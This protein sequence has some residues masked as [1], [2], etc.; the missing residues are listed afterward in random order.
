[1]SALKK[2]LVISLHGIRT[3]GEWQK[4]FCP[5]ISELGWKYYPLDYGYFFAAQLLNPFSHGS[6]V[7]W[8]RNEIN[9]I[10][11]ENGGVTPSIVV[12]SFGSLILGKAIQKYPDLKFD[13]I[14][15]TGSIMSRCFPWKSAYEKE[16]FTHVLNIIGKKDI[17]S[18]IAHYV[19][20][21]GGKSG[22][23]GFYE[24]SLIEQVEEYSYDQFG[25]GDAHFSDVFTSR[26]IPFLES[27]NSISGNEGTE[28]YLT[29]V[30]PQKAACWTVVT[31]VRQFID[32]FEDALK[33]NHFYP[34]SI[35]EPVK[36]S[37]KTFPTELVVLIPD[38]PR[39]ASKLGRELLC[40]KLKL[41][42][43]A[44]GPRSERTALISKDGILYDLPSALESFAVYN[45]V[46]NKPSGGSEALSEFKTI[47]TDVI[48]RRFG[49][50]GS[51][52]RIESLTEVLNNQEK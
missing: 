28:N 49:S 2:R 31:Y 22:A 30:T 10:C 5:Y 47:L 34:R 42:P 51:S 26:V 40:K 17:W 21:G 37:I 19:V 25:H 20:D 32:R 7:L 36:D 23:A 11:E 1:M 43:I 14:V 15:L 33:D 4:K 12:H 52:V 46:N 6:K 50:L 16:Q 24:E 9:R 27:S 13:K 3:R 44:F 41:Q 48:K 29:F 38:N 39:D 8:F 35:E 45:E 18:K